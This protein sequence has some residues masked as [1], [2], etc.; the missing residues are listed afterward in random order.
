MPT[1][2]IIDNRQEKLV[3][4]IRC[5]LASS[6]AAHF[7]VGYFFL[8]GLEAVADQLDRV[9]TLRLLI[10]NT[11]NQATIEQLAE[12]Y[13]RLEQ[14]TERA[15]AD[16]YPKRVE[17]AQRVRDTAGQLAGVLAAA[18]QTDAAEQLAGSLVQLIEAGRL[19]VRVYTRGRLHAKA[20][21]FDYGPVF[22]DRGNAVP[23]EERG[24]AVVGSSNF[25]LGGVAHNTELNVLV[26]GNANH[27]ALGEWFEALWQEA[28][29]FDQPLMHELRQGWPLA[30]VT[31]YEIYLKVLYELVRDRL[32]E[33]P[34]AEFLW[35]SEIM[36]ALADFQRNAVRRAVSMI[37]QY[38]GCFV[39]D[40]VGLGKSYVGAAIVKHFERA[41]RVRP[42]IVCPAPLV[43][44]WEHY[45]E[46]YQLNARVVSLG[47]LRDGD[48]N[49]NFLLDEDRFRDRDFVLVDES[50]NFRNPS[51][52]RYRVLQ[53]FLQT[54]DR[55]C[56]LLT[57]TPRNKS[58]ID[59]YHQLRLFH[60]GDKTLLPIDP[61]DL[62]EYFRLVEKGERSLP[63]LLTGIL[64]RRTR[65][66]ILRWYGHDAETHQRVDPDHFEPYRTGERRAYVEVAGR[67]QFFPRRRLHTVEYSIEAT[68]RG[69]YE[70]LRGYLAAPAGDPNFRNARHLSYARYGLWHYVLPERRTQRPYNELRRAGI[71]LRGLMRVSLF[72]RLESS[73]EAFRYTLQRMIGSQSAFIQAM[74]Q[75]IV[76]AGEDAQA[77]LYESDLYAEQYLLDAL[78]AVS[79]RYRI[80]DFNADA[81]RADI[82]HDVQLLQEMLRLVTPITPD[83]DAKLQT[84][85]HW[86]HVGSDGCGPVAASKCL[87][88]TQYAD[89]ARY[90]HEQMNPEGD[91]RI[92]VI[93]S[94]SKDKA[95]VVGRFAP[96]AN[97]EQSRATDQSEIDLLIATDVLSEGLNMQDCDCVIN[98]DLHWNPVRLIQRFGRVDRIGSEHAEVHGFNFLPETELER[99]LGLRD[100]LRRRIQEIHDTLGEDA[101]ILDPSEQLNEEAVYAIYQDGVIDRF[102]DDG[103]DDLVDLNE[104]EEIIRQLKGD[105]PA[106]FGRITSLRD[107]IRCARRVGQS[108]TIVLCRAGTYR[109][110]YL[111]DDTNRVI[112][113]DMPVILGQLK[114]EPDTPGEPLS[115]GYNQ[116][117]MAVREMFRTEV[118]ARRAEQ[119]H[120]LSLTHGQR[121]VLRELRLLRSETT[122][123]DLQAQID[124]LAGIFRKPITEAVRAELNAARRAEITGYDL[125]DV[126][127]RLHHRHNLAQANAGR[128]TDA[129]D[130]EFPVIVCSEGLI[131]N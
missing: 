95:E 126:L 93:Y 110:L 5:I 14:A 17:S 24:I 39:A 43:P 104:A 73:V 123:Q 30:Q 131:C 71:N 69:L 15:E 112:T 66:D 96:R 70:Q 64:I 121:Y 46:A 25:T 2:D 7:A 33:G 18:D 119:T 85:L 49:G 82:E 91:P 67:A 50:H 83:N 42:L 98:Y 4:H 40:V 87:I 55:R 130:E 37:R 106:T 31:P 8:S 9:A 35:K 84:L 117:V 59:I 56:V 16:R 3:D 68:Y 80:E 105:D 86:L 118:D 88:F 120:A 51:A 63:P 65:H 75:G 127:D 79:G 111:V 28:E 53:A 27:A 89:T 122:D 41:E 108:G 34:A 107:G 12:G 29:P 36:A 60:T 6:Q 13:R 26:H 109:Q 81:M 90:L 74:D 99:N 97:P 128:T 77:I 92:E 11:S 62:R 125:L 23:R 78:A 101:A 10:G 129:V 58:A 54:G 19:H 44:M 1:H 116:R 113:R 21:I 52:Q 57:A 38:G 48:D 114:C 20:Y 102:E 103:E 94:R 124:R 47:L 72:K 100:K 32:E 76:P 22:D 115:T 61:P 45:N